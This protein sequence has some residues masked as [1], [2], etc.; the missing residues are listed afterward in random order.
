MS[1]RLFLN[2]CTPYY[3]DGIIYMNIIGVLNV[4]YAHLVIFIGFYL[5]TCNEGIFYL[6]YCRNMSDYLS[7]SLI[8]LC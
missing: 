1:P 8:F 7:S 6:L 2:F 3:S 5:A 4:V